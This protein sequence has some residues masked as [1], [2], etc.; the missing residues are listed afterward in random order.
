MARRTIVTGARTNTVK[1]DASRNEAPRPVRSACFQYQKWNA[2]NPP[3]INA[4]MMKNG[5]LRRRYA[6]VIAAYIVTTGA[7]GNVPGVSDGRAILAELQ[8]AGVADP[9]LDYEAVMAELAAGAPPLLVLR[10]AAHGIAV[11]RLTAVQSDQIAELPG[12]AREP[13]LLQEP[14]SPPVVPWHRLAGDLRRTTGRVLDAS[15]R[16]EQFSDHGLWIC[17]FT[18]DG[19]ARGG[20]GFTDDERDPEGGLADF[21]DK[22]CEGWLHEE[23]WGGWPMCPRHPDRPMW[24]TVGRDDLAAWQCEADSSDEIAVG[25]LGL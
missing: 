7:V 5:I 16:W 13:Y 10:P 17:D 18:L 15:F 23:V 20:F 19:G 25:Q 21:A 1:R 4:V 14:P 6:P 9:S 2:T 24:A 8:Q 11:V 12:I 3:A 22:L